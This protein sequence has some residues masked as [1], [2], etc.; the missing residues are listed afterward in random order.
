MTLLSASTGLDHV[1][2]ALS[3]HV[4]VGRNVTHSYWETC[5]KVSLKFTIILTL[6]LLFQSSSLERLE[7]AMETLK[8][9]LEKQ[10]YSF[11]EALAEKESD[12]DKVSDTNI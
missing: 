3:R 2:N 8:M 11:K 7:V 9:D 10:I 4:E 12:Y 6:F 1:T 5:S